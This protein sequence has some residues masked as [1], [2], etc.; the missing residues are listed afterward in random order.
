[1][2]H[3]Y[4]FVKCIGRF[5]WPMGRML[6]SGVLWQGSRFHMLG[7]TC[8]TLGAVLAPIDI[9]FRRGSPKLSA[10]EKK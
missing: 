5:K 10:S 9:L 7:T 8:L 3:N 2:L 1:M 6:V 4:Y